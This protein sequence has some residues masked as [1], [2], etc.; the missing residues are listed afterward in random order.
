M[1]GAAKRQAAEERKLDLAVTCGN[2]NRK[3]IGAKLD[4]FAFLEKIVF[5][6]EDIGVEGLNPK[7]VEIDGLPM[8]ITQGNGGA[9][10]KNESVF[11]GAE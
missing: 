4:S 5:R 3:G 2:E 10:I 6:F 11:K 8:A 1:S 7:E 9:A